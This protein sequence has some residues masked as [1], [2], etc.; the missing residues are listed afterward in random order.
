MNFVE[1]LTLLDSPDST[2]VRI[3]LRCSKWI[4]LFSSERNIWS[5]PCIVMQEFA[6]KISRKWRKSNIWYFSGNQSRC[7]FFHVLRVFNR[8]LKKSRENKGSQILWYFA[9]NQ[10]R[11]GFSMLWQYLPKFSREKRG[12]QV[13][14]IWQDFVLRIH[15]DFRL[16]CDFIFFGNRGFVDFVMW[17]KINSTFRLKNTFWWDDVV[18]VWL[19]YKHLLKANPGR[20]VRFA[21]F[22]TMSTSLGI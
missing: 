7:G 2:V 11:F 6:E 1:F 19:T 20:N 5:L 3:E 17:R 9:G 10:S 4:L 12:S 21:P 22:E 18:I 8:V 13:L 16:Y 15:F 14:F